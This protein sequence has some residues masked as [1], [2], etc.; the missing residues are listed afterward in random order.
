[1]TGIKRNLNKYLLVLSLRLLAATKPPSVDNKHRHS[2]GAG[3]GHHGYIDEVVRLLRGQ[4]QMKLD[5]A[6]KDGTLLPSSLFTTLQFSGDSIASMD[7]ASAVNP[8]CWLVACCS[9]CS[10]PTRTLHGTSMPPWLDMTSN[11]VSI[12]VRSQ[13]KLGD[14]RGLEHLH[15]ERRMGSYW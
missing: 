13:I 6:D 11:A 5:E 15:S 7:C 9:E 8:K 14:R 3:S 2:A 1:M 10:Q 4:K 12:P